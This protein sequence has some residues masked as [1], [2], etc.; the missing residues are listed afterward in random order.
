M[1]INFPK[2]AHCPY[3][4]LRPEAES[5]ATSVMTGEPPLAGAWHMRGLSRGDIAMMA[6]CVCGGEE[7]RVRAVQYGA[8]G[9][10]ALRL[11]RV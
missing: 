8:Q 5:T 10:T 3:A 9:H 6:V 1:E 11:G 2:E 4:V 7:L